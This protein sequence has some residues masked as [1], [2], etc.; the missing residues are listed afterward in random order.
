MK[1]AVWILLLA[2]P[3]PA[4]GQ[5]AWFGMGGFLSESEGGAAY[6]FTL[7]PAEHD[8]PRILRHEAR[9]THVLSH[10]SSDTW[11]VAGRAGQTE[12]SASPLV[13][14][15]GLRVPAK[16]WNL[17]AS[18]AFARRL[19]ERKRWGANM[20]VGSASDE[21]FHTMRE[22]EFRATVFGELPAWGR[23]SWR[24]LLSYSNNR[25]FLNNV[26]F[27]GAGYVFRDR[28]RGL[29]ATVGFPF[30]AASYRP[31]EDWRVR[32]F[33]FGPN[34]VSVDAARRL[35]SGV[36][37]YARYERD[38]DQWLRSGREHRYDRLTFESQKARLGLRVSFRSG[39]SWDLSGGREFERRFFESRDANHSH[40]ARADLGDAWVS[41]VRLS[42]RR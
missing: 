14:E 8:S 22:T 21:P 34:R 1:R 41:S 24:L 13:A 4:F 40:V 5:G 20:G 29:Q 42:W 32:A 17:Q 6:G 33:M 19:G 36:W 38:P 26:P 9:G 35:V 28:V 25:S 23:D 18:G 12:L 10:R 16:L 7:S 31:N 11:S 3:A 30:L 39:F 37:T 2:I 15:T 27:P